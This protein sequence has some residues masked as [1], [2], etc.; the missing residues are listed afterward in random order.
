M[1]ENGLD[2]SLEE[3]A[4]PEETVKE[5]KKQ[6][7]LWEEKISLKLAKGTIKNK[8][9][10][11]DLQLG[12]NILQHLQRAFD[13]QLSTSKSKQLETACQSLLAM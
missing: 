9:T 7:L 5:L 3:K 12:L 11:L 1:H 8:L 4:I 13:W 10:M 2:G 6:T